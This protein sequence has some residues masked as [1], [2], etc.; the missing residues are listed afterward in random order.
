MART[1]E[2]D[3]EEVLDKALRLFREKGYNGTSTQ[4]LVDRLSISRSSM[5][6]CYTDKLNLFLQTIRRYKETVTE[7]MVT[8][9]KNAPSLKS[10]LRQLFEE[11]ISNEEG[12]CFLASCSLESGPWRPEVARLVKENLEAVEKALAEAIKKA[13]QAGEISEVWAP[14]KMASYLYNNLNGVML[15]LS[16]GADKKACRDIASICLGVLDAPDR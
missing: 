13:Q 3:E 6:N 16:Y 2:F 15:M 9:L 12:G 11:V 1:K 7:V 10:E 8:R 14:K 5:Y 4:D